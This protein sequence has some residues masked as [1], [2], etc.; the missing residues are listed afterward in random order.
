MPG[1]SCKECGHE[2]F[3]LGNP[4]GARHCTQCGHVLPSVEPAR[5]DVMDSERQRQIAAAAA[6]AAVEPKRRGDPDCSVS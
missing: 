2:T 4:I 1:I 3:V 6:T 5:T